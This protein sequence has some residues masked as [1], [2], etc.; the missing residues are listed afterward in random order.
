MY[1]TFKKLGTS[2]FCYAKEVTIEKMVSS[3][4]TDISG[5]IYFYLSKNLKIESNIFKIKTYPLTLS[6]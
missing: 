4:E 5:F 3:K 1:F 2:L 6:L